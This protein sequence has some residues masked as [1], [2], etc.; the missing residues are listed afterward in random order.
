MKIQ[1]IFLGD[2]FIAA[3]VTQGLLFSTELTIINQRAVIDVHGIFGMEKANVQ[4]LT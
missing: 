3:A 2:F 4:A 1:I